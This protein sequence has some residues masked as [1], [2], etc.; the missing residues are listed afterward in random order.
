[1]KPTNSEYPHTVSVR[2]D[3]QGL[4]ALDALRRRKEKIAS[5]S[6]VMR[7]ALMEK[8]QREIKKSPS[9]G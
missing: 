2:V 6:E 9:K 3:D 8:Y 5:A 4:K 1:M 7:E